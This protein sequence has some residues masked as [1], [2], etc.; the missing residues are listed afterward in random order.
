MR[1]QSYNRSIRL[2]SLPLHVTDRVCTHDPRRYTPRAERAARRTAFA[3]SVRGV[4]PPNDGRFHF[5]Y[6]TIRYAPIH[7]PIISRRPV[8]GRG[9]RV[10][11]NAR[12][13][14]LIFPAAYRSYR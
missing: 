11:A 6:F 10:R 7:R 3:V 2:Q 14:I 1:A 5:Q 4:S 13:C 8:R 9:G 12:F